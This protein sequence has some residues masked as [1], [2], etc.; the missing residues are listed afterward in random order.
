MRLFEGNPAP[1]QEK[2]TA[3]PIFWL[4]SIVANGWMD[5]ECPYTLQWA[6]LFRLDHI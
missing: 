5:Q 3:H 2:G 6:P 4:M 1:P